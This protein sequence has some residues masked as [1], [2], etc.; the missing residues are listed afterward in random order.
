KSNAAFPP[1]NSVPRAEWSAPG[2]QATATAVIVCLID[3]GGISM[4]IVKGTV[5]ALATAATVAFS[6]AAFA[7]GEGSGNFIWMRTA[8]GVHQMRFTADGMKAF[9]SHHPK[10]LPRGTIVVRSGN[11]LYLMEDPKGTAF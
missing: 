8:D 6:G 4:S 5:I 9:M 1:A 3:Y 10:K 2:E 7:Q 11:D